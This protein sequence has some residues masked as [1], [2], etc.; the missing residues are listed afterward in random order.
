MILSRTFKF[1]TRESLINFILDVNPMVRT[2]SSDTLRARI[3]VEGE[4]EA[5]QMDKSVHDSGGTPVAEWEEKW[6]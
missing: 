2:W 4:D 5:D 1:P 3:T 6:L